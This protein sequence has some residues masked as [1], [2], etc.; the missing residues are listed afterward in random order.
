LTQEED[1]QYTEIYQHSI[2]TAY[3][4]FIHIS[5]I[6]VQD[7]IETI[8]LPWP[9]AHILLRLVKESLGLKAVG[10]YKIPCE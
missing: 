5:R 4:E 2:S 8:H 3:A 10:V 9:K 6:M 7:N 1:R